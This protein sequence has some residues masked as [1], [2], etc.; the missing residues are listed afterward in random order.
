[1]EDNNTET[2]IGTMFLDKL[3]AKHKRANIDQNTTF[4]ITDE[5]A[6]GRFAGH[7][8]TSEDF[9]WHLQSKN[10]RVQALKLP[11]AKGISFDKFIKLKG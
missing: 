1:M 9:T 5:D 11:V 8:I 6:F 4:T 3:S 2:K 7:L 10:L